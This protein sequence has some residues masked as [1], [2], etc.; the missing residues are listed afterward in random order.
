M[1]TPVGIDVSG[2]GAASSMS[3]VLPRDAARAPPRPNA[4]GG[5]TLDEVPARIVAVK[6]FAGVVTDGEVRRQRD[7]L[8]AAIETDGGTAPVETPYPRGTRTHP[9]TTRYPNPGTAPVEAGAFS[10]LQP[11]CNCA[12]LCSK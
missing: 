6:A 2:G 3:F 1:T 10:V 8:E 9:L 4:D 7:A 5:V 11:S 12:F